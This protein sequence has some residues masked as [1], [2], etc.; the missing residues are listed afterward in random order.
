MDQEEYLKTRLYAEIE[1]YEMKSARNKKLYLGLLSIQ[2]IMATALLLISIFGSPDNNTMRFFFIV[3]PAI[4]LL[5][6]GL[7]AVHKYHEHWIKYR[8]SAESLKHVKYHFETNSPPFDGDDAFNQL[9][10]RVEALISPDHTDRSEP[11]AK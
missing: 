9:V 1:W 10:V 7:A 6:I 3:F 2:L 4:I 5:C 11:K 8:T